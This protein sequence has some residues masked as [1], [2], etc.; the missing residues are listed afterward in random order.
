MSKSRREFLTTTAASAAALATGVG[1]DAQTPPPASTP[2][3]GT[4]PAFGTAP[5]VGPEVTAATFAEAEKLVRVEMTPKEQAQVAGNWRQAMAPTMERRTGPR[6]VALETSLAPASLWNPMIP[7]IVGGP[8]ARPIRPRESRS[9]PVPKRDDDIAFAPVTA[10]SRWIESRALTSERLTRIYLE[11]LERFDPKLKCVITLTPELALEQARRADAE[12]A[13]GKYRGPLH[14]IPWGVKDLL[15]TKGIRT[16]WGAEPYRDRVPDADAV[17]VERLHRAG[18]VLVAKLCLGA[19][20]LN[21]IWF[22]GQTMNPWLLEEGSGGSS[23]GPGAA[24]AA[25]LRRLLDR[26]RDGRE[27]R[28]PVDALRRDGPAA[29]VRARGAHGRDDAVLVDG[30]AGPDDARRRGHVARPRR[31]LR[32]GP[33]RPLERAEPSRLR[34]GR[35]RGRLTRRVLPGVDEGEPGDR[36]GPRR[37]RDRP[38]PRD[39]A[40]RGEPAGLAV[41]LAEHDSLRRSGG[42]VR[43][44][45][46]LAAASTSS[47]CRCRTPGRTRSASRAS[48]RPSTTCRPTGCAA[49]W[50]TRWRGSSR[51]STCCSSRRCATRS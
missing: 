26:Q 13:A 45:D 27:H 1:A 47:R 4:P 9:G 43:G 3:A 36:G 51:R 48:S 31:D 30:Q 34:G 15:D 49:R 7:G 19:L 12:I 20:A 17:V 35:R 22:G 32:P 25:G 50:R 41:R 28:R 29:D 8:G 44:A 16:T 14:G 6:K 46:A 5:A 11:R 42:R 23:A 24:T 2:V 10:L 18:A 21:D 33:G 38:P 39:G 37:A 40:G